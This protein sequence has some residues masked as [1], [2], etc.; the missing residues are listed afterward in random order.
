MKSIRILSLVSVLALASVAQAQTAPTRSTPCSPTTAWNAV[1]VGLTPPTT[2][3]DGLPLPSGTVLTYRAEDRLG[4]SGTFATVPHR[5]RISYGCTLSW[6][7]VSP[8][9][10]T[11]PAKA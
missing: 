5:G 1:C 9:P 11:W 10:A 6:V 8:G 2:Y 7:R 3:S 4:A